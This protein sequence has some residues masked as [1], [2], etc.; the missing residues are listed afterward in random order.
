[1]LEPFTVLAFLIVVA[2]GAYVQTVTGFALGLIVMG[3]ITLLELAPV[4][5]TAIVIGF[6]ALVNNFFALQKTLHHV[7]RRSLLYT[8]LGMLPA[9]YVGVLILGHLNVH[10]L[11]NLRMLL[12]VVILVGGILLAL[13]PK[14]HAR[15][16]AGWVDSGIGVI[17][18]IL[19]GMFSVGGPP[20]VFHFYRQPL[21]L[22]VVRATLLA[23]FAFTTV[24]RLLYV[25]LGGDITLKM[26]ELSLYCLPVV[27]L[28]TLAGRR[29]PPPLPDLAM[30]RFAFLLLG[31]IGLLLLLL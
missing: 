20:L 19:A 23:C 29:Y 8:L 21:R 16:A 14:P 30:R 10:S 26:V 9:T 1:M 7:D 24:A 13:R 27:Y 2:L 17:G 28:A 22:A 25:G 4:G 15:R 3:G 12:G 31:L 6:T 11:E 5:F 18:G